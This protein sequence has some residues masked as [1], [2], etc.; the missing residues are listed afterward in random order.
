MA[1]KTNYEANGSTYYRIRHKVE[2]ADGS[3][4]I[5]AFYGA[6]KKDAENKYKEFLNEQAMLRNKKLD[7]Y[8]TMTLGARMEEYVTGTL[9]VSQ[10]FAKGT[11][12]KYV[13][14]WKN[15][16]KDAPIAEMLVKD[17]RPS[18]V[19]SFYN[20]L[21]VSA[22]T[23]KNIDK[24][25]KNFFKWLMLNDYAPNVMVAV[26]IPKKEANSRNDGIVVWEDGELQSILTSLRSPD[27]HRL[28][29][30]VYVLSY[31][32]MRISEVL[33]L[34]YG[35]IRDGHIYVDRQYYL[36]ELKEPKYGSKRIIP[37]HKDLEEPFKLHKAWHDEEA[38]NRGYETDFIFT[39]NKGRLYD[40]S[41]VRKALER[42][43]KANNIP[44]KHIHAYRATF[45]TNLCR[46]DIPLQIASKILGHKSLEVTAQ[47]YALVR[48]DSIDDAFKDFVLF[49]G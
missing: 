17:V 7:E 42:F 14:A 6:S 25:M 33:G 47:H 40:R 49:G 4:K 5:K 2:L 16:V 19:Q 1:T 8:D 31:T 24:F 45:C 23:I 27:A 11:I 10:K 34:K 48:Q 12:N 18:H 39:T 37:F 35:D 30:M 13:G 3:T 46:C 22:Q 32:G 41:S 15:H 43:Y 26:E 28:F 38:K 9:T 20:S 21:D 44:Y 29:F 36:G